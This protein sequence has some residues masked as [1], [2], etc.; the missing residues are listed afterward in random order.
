MTIEG[1][2]A[3]YAETFRKDRKLFRL[4]ETERAEIVLAANKI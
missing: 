1:M 4:R 3:L 2:N